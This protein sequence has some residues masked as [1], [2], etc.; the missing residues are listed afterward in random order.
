MP[1]DYAYASDGRYLVSAVSVR[2]ETT[3][4]AIHTRPDMLDVICCEIW[5]VSRVLVFVDR[6]V[7]RRSP[8]G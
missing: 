6:V 5:Q 7:G 3:S 1:A 8:K 4:F 2:V